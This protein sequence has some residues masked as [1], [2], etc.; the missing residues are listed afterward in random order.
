MWAEKTYP[1]LPEFSRIAQNY[2]NAGTINLDFM[3]Q[4]DASRE[5][6]NTWVEDKTNNKIKDL[7]P[8]GSI[9]PDTKLVI[10]NALYFKGTWV[11]Q[12]S[13]DRTKVDKFVLPTGKS[14]DV[15]MMQTFQAEGYNYAEYGRMQFLEMPYK[16][17]SRNELSML[18]VLPK[19][20][21]LAET[22]TYLAGHGLS[23]VKSKLISQNVMVYLPK[24]RI[25]TTYSLV[26]NLKAMGMPQ[27]FSSNADF[28]G[29]DGRGDLSISDVR[30]KTYIDVDE[31]GT[32]GAAATEIGWRAMG[33]NYTP[34]TVFRADHPFIFF[35]QDKETGA[36]LFMGRVMNPNN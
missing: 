18:V 22:D 16:H 30:H 4:P 2:Y 6:I 23:D 8:A 20:Q 36:I 31:E 25:E 5:R 3:S 21:S 33:V 27:A 12:F 28:S 1:F 17:N 34:P 26:N 29:M 15:Q 13:K 11:N 9:T 7:L 24:F 35:I 10:T 32:E 19:G 14:V